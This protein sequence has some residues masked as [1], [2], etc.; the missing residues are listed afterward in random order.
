ML[1]KRGSE[2]PAPSMVQGYWVAGQKTSHNEAVELMLF[3]LLWRYIKRI[4][5]FEYAIYSVSLVVLRLIRQSQQDCLRFGAK[6][7]R[8]P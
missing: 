5:Y 3:N 8:P 7:S 6:A 1:V 4:V 2:G